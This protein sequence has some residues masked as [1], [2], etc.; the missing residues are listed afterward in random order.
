MI[1]ESIILF[2]LI[3]DSEVRGHHFRIITHRSL[4][5]LSKQP[6]HMHDRHAARVYANDK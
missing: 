3:K 2:E 5:E 4:N 1:E 6:K